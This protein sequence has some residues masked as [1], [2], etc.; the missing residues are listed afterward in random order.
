[1]CVC[2]S[3]RVLVYPYTHVRTLVHMSIYTECVY[4][5]A[6]RNRTTAAT[7][8]WPSP[9]W[10]VHQRPT[11]GAECQPEDLPSSGWSTRKPPLEWMGYPQWTS[12]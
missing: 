1:M 4:I 11:P 6:K 3:T 10:G 8:I 5:Y 2:V 12:P 7:P 9:E